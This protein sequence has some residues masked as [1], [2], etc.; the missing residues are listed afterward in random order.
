MSATSSDDVDRL[1]KLVLHNPLTLNLLGAATSGDQVRWGEWLMKVL[2]IM[3]S[4][5]GLLEWWEWM[6]HNQLTLNLL[7]AATSGDQVRQRHEFCC[8]WAWVHCG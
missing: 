3:L 5:A 4:I 6:L 8:G 7:G 1:T 2:S